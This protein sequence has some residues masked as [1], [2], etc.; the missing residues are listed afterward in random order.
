MRSLLLLTQ[1]SLSLTLCRSIIPANET[2][3]RG[4]I[5][6]RVQNTQSGFTSH[7]NGRETWR[8]RFAATGTI[9]TIASKSRG[10]SGGLAAQTK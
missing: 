1:F 8:L 6:N 3:K 7:D 10:A 5:E 9:S 2:R 4:S